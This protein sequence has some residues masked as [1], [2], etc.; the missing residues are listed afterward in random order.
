M[1]EKL[2]KTA[3]RFYFL[4]PSYIQRTKLLSPSRATTG[5]LPSP[6]MNDALPTSLAIA[7]LLK[8]NF[9]FPS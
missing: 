8:Q 7:F 2:M 3:T 1:N 4:I 9:R 5:E 6:L